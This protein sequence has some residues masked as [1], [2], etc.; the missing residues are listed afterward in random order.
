M[1]PMSV[2]S[3]FCQAEVSYALA[4][5][6]QCDAVPFGVSQL[7][8]PTVL[9]GLGYNAANSTYRCGTDYGRQF[10]PTNVSKG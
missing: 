1:S 3:I 4:L 2:E 10:M 8:N 9:S 5:N 7:A 6:K